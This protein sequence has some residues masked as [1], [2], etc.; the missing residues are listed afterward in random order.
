MGFITSVLKV[1]FGIMAA[2]LFIAIIIGLAITSKEGKK[3]GQ[4]AVQ[5][6]HEDVA[7]DV[8]QQYEIAKRNGSKMDACV[9]AGFVAEAYLQAKNEAEYT[10]WKKT[11]RKDCAAAGLSR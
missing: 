4:D 8:V 1:A 5:E 6:I 10:T 9:R 11:Q 2:I 3:A 7:R